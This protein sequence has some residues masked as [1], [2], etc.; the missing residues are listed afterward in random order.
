MKI[1]ARNVHA[2]SLLLSKLLPAPQPRPHPAERPLRKLLRVRPEVRTPCHEQ[3][4]PKHDA[5]EA[6]PNVALDD[7]VA[8]GGLVS[9][10]NVT[11]IQRGNAVRTLRKTSRR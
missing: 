2:L 6:E 9:E 11:I 10:R 5:E 4:R 7:G 1:L 3:Q 8:V